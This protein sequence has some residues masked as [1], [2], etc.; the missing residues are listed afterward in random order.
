MSGR[1]HALARALVEHP[2]L[3]LA[4]MLAAAAL[5]AVFALGL[6]TDMSPDQLS[7]DVGNQS[8]I[9]RAFVESFGNPNN[10]V[11][12]LYQAQDVTTPKSLT[13]LETV[14]RRFD[15]KDYATNVMSLARL[16]VLSAPVPLPRVPAALASGEIHLEGAVRSASATDEDTTRA[17]LALARAPTA[18]GTLVSANRDVAA[19]VVRLRD[20]ID[21][22]P[23]IEPVVR[24]IEDELADLERSLGVELQIIGLPYMRSWIIRQVQRDQS[25]L[26]PAAIALALLLLLATFRWLPA[27]F[28]PAMAVSV[29]ALLLVGLMSAVGEPINIINN[30]VPVLIIIVGISDCIHLINR[31]GEELALGHDRREAATRSLRSMSIALFLTS[32]TTA[33]GFASLVVS[34]ASLLQRFGITAAIG[35]LIAYVVTVTGLPVM[36]S[37][38]PRPK[39]TIAHREAGRLE[40]MTASIVSAA[41]ARRGWV[42]TGAALMAAAFIAVALRLPIDNHVSDQY[43]EGNEIYKTMQLVDDRLGG[44]QVLEV[45]LT[46]DSATTFSEPE[47]LDDLDHVQAWLRRQPGVGA[48]VGYPDFLRQVWATLAPGPRPLSDPLRAAPTESLVALGR[49]GGRAAAQFRTVDG[50]TMRI[51]VFMRDIGGRR[52]LALADDLRQRLSSALG[53]SAIDVALSGEGYVTALGLS[54]VVS[55]LLK[56]LALACAVIFAFLTLVLR[57]ARLGLASVPP[58]L[59]P[60]LATMAY[61]HARGLTLGPATTIIFAVSIGLAVDGTIHVLA[62]FREEI[63]IGKD[64]QAAL[65]AAAAGTGK[66]VVV[67]YLSLIAGFMVLQLSAFVPIRLFGEL[68]SITIVGCLVSTL[69]VLPPL[70]T[71]FWPAKR[72]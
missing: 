58:N 37:L 29:S 46:A 16:P 44:V 19:V 61:M 20:D 47:V 8:A 45:M 65:A 41:C 33:A 6:R 32:A 1:L 2:K 51:T 27:L 68:I 31:Y 24:D 36:L 67:S 26:F 9:D 62:R 64:T 49:L 40:R 23:E 55:D 22:D 53:S 57:S 4:T 28:L 11:L 3:V 50:K 38:L 39:H 10:A 66:A 7:A 25:T 52:L 60:L 43:D 15:D 70:V 14:A 12:V 71:V 21:R 13:I 30:I 48:V 69:V 42:L 18:I 35:M 34:K 59:L 54:I 56:S 17:R 72:S 5:A 63:G